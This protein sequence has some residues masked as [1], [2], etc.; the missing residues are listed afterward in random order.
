MISK[1]GLRL[2]ITST[3]NGKDNKFHELWT[4]QDSA[5]SRHE[6]NIHQAVADGLDRDIGELRRALKDEDAWVQ[7]YELQFLEEASAW[8]SYDLITAC[9]HGD[10]GKPE[11][12]RGG[13]CFVGNDIARRRDLWVAWVWELVGDVLWT[14]EIV[15]RKGISFAEQDAEIDR[16]MNA[17]RVTRLVMDQT[18]MGEKPV[19]DAQRRYGVHRVEGVLLSGATP[20]NVATAAKQAFEDRRARIPAGNVVLRADLHKIKKVVGAT[21]APRLIADRDGDGHADRAW[22]CFLGV[23]GA[24][25]GLPMPAGTSVDAAEDTYQP[26]RPGLLSGNSFAR[27]MGWPR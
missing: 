2:R 22:A 3:P 9:E 14:R 5:W 6:V 21:G 25:T 7:E 16:L 23:A 15:E 13:P 18:G 10:A 12:Y 26:D 20:L 17:Y 4:A 11:L 1:A 8:L 27:R 24:D 19:E